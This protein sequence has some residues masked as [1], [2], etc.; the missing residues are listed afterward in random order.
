MAIA[1]LGWGSLLWDLDNLAPHVH[2]DWALQSGP[3]LPMEFSR[4][5][6]KRR[7]GLVVCLDT[8]HGVNC[9]THAITSTRP[10]LATAR[11]DLA[12]RERAPLE[13]IG[14]ASAKTGFGRL[15]EVVTAVQ[16]WCAIQGWD[17]AVWTDLE[18]NFAAHTGQN[19]TL[20]AAFAYLQTL[21]GENLAE[22]HRYI[23][24]APRWTQ[25]PLRNQLQLNPWWQALN[26]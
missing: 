7:M 5:S 13:R 6:P 20:A 24:N 3:A 15:P 21:T 11:A 4:I 25:T 2:G 19:Y 12:L 23:Q 18:P 22:A 9:P 26:F 16:N 14:Y 17:G 10:D 8:T 1:V